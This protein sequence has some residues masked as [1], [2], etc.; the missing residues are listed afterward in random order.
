M[1]TMKKLIESKGDKKL[2]NHK[3]EKSNGISSYIYH[4]TVICGANDKEK[5][6]YTN[7]GGWGTRSTTCAINNYVWELTQ[8]GYKQVSMTEFCN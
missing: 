6:F 7:N 1:V 8:R 4:W 2:G 3:V 5:I